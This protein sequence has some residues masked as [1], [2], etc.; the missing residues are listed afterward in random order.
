MPFGVQCLNHKSIIKTQKIH[1]AMQIMTNSI[2]KIL[3]RGLLLLPPLAGRLHVVP[4]GPLQPPLVVH[5][6][7]LL[8]NLRKLHEFLDS[9]L[10]KSLLHICKRKMKIGHYAC[11]LEI[12]FLF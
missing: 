4:L 12:H 7:T 8:P 1:S 5:L 6:P 9:G 10:D 11:F 2:F 3:Q